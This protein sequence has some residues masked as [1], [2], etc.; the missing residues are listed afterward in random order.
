MKVAVEG[1]TYEFKDKYA[2]KTMEAQKV[3]TVPYFNLNTTGGS[4]DEYAVNYQPPSLKLQTDDGKN[5]DAFYPT[6]EKINIVCDENEA[7]LH[8]M[9]LNGVVVSSRV[10]SDSE[11]S[12]IESGSKRSYAAYL[13]RTA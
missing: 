1:C 2:V 12:Y 8:G 13:T 9:N 11:L 4:G 5:I 7:T 10:L 3:K 6:D